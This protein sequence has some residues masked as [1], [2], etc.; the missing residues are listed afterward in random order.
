MLYLGILLGIGIMGGII[1]LAI[2]K[3]STFIV[4]VASLIALGIMIL[5]IIICLVMVFTDNRVPVDESVLIVGAPA[6]VKKGN[7]QNIWVLLL[8]IIVLVSIFL[9]III[10]AMK[11]NRKYMSKSGQNN[12]GISGKF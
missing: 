7:T 5:T 10:L 4:R 1:F 2:D 9:T 6:E 12:I 3:K 11:E 8:L